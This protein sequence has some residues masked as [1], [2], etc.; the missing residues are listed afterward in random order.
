MPS[1]KVG[2]SPSQWRKSALSN[3]GE[4]PLGRASSFQSPQWRELALNSGTSSLGVI[5]AHH[6]FGVLNPHSISVNRSFISVTPV[7]HLNEPPVSHRGADCHS[8]LDGD[9]RY[10]KMSFC[11][12]TPSL[13]VILLVLTCHVWT[14]CHLASGCIAVLWFNYMLISCTIHHHCTF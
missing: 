2:I 9:K 4:V 13:A 12:P 10:G 6:H 5:T 1:P 7:Y 3:C 8:S 11:P 14:K